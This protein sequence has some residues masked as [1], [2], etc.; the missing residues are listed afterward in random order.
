VFP[1]KKQHPGTKM[2]K[3]MEDEIK[4]Q[5]ERRKKKKRKSE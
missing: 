4:S 3:N 5:E 2:M 1:F